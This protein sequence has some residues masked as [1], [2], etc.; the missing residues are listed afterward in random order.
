M[1]LYHIKIFILED[2]EEPESIEGENRFEAMMRRIEFRK[3]KFYRKMNGLPT[4]DKNM[5][6]HILLNIYVATEQKIN[7]LRDKLNIYKVS[8]TKGSNVVYVD[9]EDI[10]MDSFTQFLG[11]NHQK[12]RTKENFFSSKT[13]FNNYFLTL[14]S[15][16]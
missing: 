14:A 10:F 12:V 4:S 1:A 8:F 11:M 2:E 9:R 7:Y 5:S 3:N 16:Y 15:L 13:L 6:K